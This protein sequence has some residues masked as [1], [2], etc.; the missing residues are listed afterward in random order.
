MNID[1]YLISVLCNQQDYSILYPLV[2]LSRPMPDH[3]MYEISTVVANKNWFDAIGSCTIQMVC[4]L[5]NDLK[6][7][8]YKNSFF[9]SRKLFCSYPVEL[10]ESIILIMLVE[11]AVCHCVEIFEPKHIQF[12]LQKIHARFGTF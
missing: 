11:T 7:W 9:V 3:E 10:V 5:T 2:W 12:L 6:K 8:N 1:K 4:I